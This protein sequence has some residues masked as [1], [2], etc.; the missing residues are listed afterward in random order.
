MMPSRPWRA[1]A[2]LAPAAITTAA[3]LTVPAASAAAAS[4]SWQ[5]TNEFASRPVCFTTAGGTSDLAIDLNGNWS[6]PINIGASGLAAGIS[7]AGT[8]LIDFYYGTDGT[9]TGSYTTPPIPAG[10]S[11]GTGPVRV[12]PQPDPQSYTLDAEGYVD[13]K[14]AAGLPAN[15]SFNIM[16]WANDGTT[17]Q[18]ETVTVTIMSSC[19]RHY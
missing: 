11:N 18:T 14:A 12:V 16:L 5:L 3:A 15:S 9:D 4:P 17:K 19:K 8:T 1:A 10:W 2:Q 6:T 13:V 7:V